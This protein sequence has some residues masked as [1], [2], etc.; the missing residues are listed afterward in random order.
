MASDGRKSAWAPKKRRSQ[1]STSTGADS[2]DQGIE[3]AD[4]RAAHQELEAQ[5]Q[6]IFNKFNSS[7][8]YDMMRGEEETRRLARDIWAG[9]LVESIAE[10]REGNIQLV[11]ILRAQLANTGE[12]TEDKQQRDEQHIDGILADICRAQNIHKIPL[13]TAATSIVCEMN[14]VHREYHDV[15]SFHHKGAALSEK[16]VHDFLALANEER[17][18]PRELFIRGIVACCFDN[19][20]IKIDYSA[21]SSDGETGRRLDMTN[22]FSLRLPLHLAP[23]IDA[24]SICTPHAPLPA[25]LYPCADHQCVTAF[26]SQSELAH[27]DMIFHWTPLAVYFS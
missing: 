25:S 26:V 23:K 15:I 22:W 21:Y 9:R 12:D 8:I 18:L 6:A 16:W 14:A 1:V 4:L 2:D 5:Q 27:S 11:N 20:S 10:L 13:L 3:L 19:L 7:C 24:A 17:P